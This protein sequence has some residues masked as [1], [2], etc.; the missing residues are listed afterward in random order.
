MT[1]YL[2][3]FFEFFKIGLFA[4]GG[5]LATLPFL[6]ELID[7]YHWFSESDLLN[8]VAVGESTPGPIGVNMATYVGFHVT[9]SVLGAITTTLGLV[10]PSVIIICI[11]A[12]ALRAFSNN[13]YVKSAFYGLRPAVGA[14]IFC[15]GITVLI[16]TL[17][18]NG[19]IAMANLN[20]ISLVI[21]VAVF[22]VSMFYK[23]LHPILLICICG[24]AGI[25]L[26]L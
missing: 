1:I 12:R 4:L 24:V 11:V 8:M 21:F 15:S 19:Q 13:F 5:G 9:G 7:K 16:T 14:M 20:W 25:L 3:L 18:L 10:A 23:K 26:Q 17:F 6:E 22:A 2:T